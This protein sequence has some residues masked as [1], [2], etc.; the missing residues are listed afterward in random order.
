MCT[1][2]WLDVLGASASAAVLDVSAAPIRRVLALYPHEP[3]PSI[4]CHAPLLPL[5]PR[6]ALVVE[7]VT[8]GCHQGAFY[9]PPLVR[10]ADPSLISACEICCA[11]VGAFLAAAATPLRVGSGRGGSAPSLAPLDEEAQLRLLEAEL[12]SRAAPTYRAAHRKGPGPAAVLRYASATLLNRHHA[13][14]LRA[15]RPSDPRLASE[16][17]AGGGGRVPRF[18]LDVTRDAAATREA[19]RPNG[20]WRDHATG[21]SI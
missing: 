13:E 4:A 12:G 18:L 1:S 14:L 5:Y 15:L 20:L 2:R 3:L 8:L 11:R 16:G 9:P 10:R 19:R 7:D 17:G 6:G 21:G